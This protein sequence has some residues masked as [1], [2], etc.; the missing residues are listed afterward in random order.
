MKVFVNSLPKSGTNLLEKLIG[1]V[2]VNRSGRSIASTNIIGRYSVLKSLLRQDHLHGCSIPVGLELP[3]SVSLKW[4]KRSLA[5]AE[6]EYLSGHAAFS[7]QLDYMVRIQG[8]RMVQIYR[9]PRAVLLSWAKYVAEDVNRW[10]PFHAFFKQMDLKDRIRFLLL[11]GDVGDGIYYS[12]F[13]E[14][15]RRSGGWMDSDNT[16]VVRFEDLV[17][18]QGGGSRDLQRE[19]IVRILN[20]IGYE[21]DQKK[22]DELQNNLFGGTHTFRGGR[23]D[24]WKDVID[25]D[26]H[27][28]ILRELGGSS[29]VRKLGYFD[30]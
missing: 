8:L 24:G 22:L 15:L 7:E 6:G 14:V 30:V 16:L 11:G 28:L 1:M 17:G 26:L 9:D 4:L 21:H 10:Y 19:T 13:K 18:A 2:G 23:V 27:E 25:A 20:H 12:S 5:I 3:V 29:I